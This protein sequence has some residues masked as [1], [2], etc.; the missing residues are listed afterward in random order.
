MYF[1]SNDVFSTITFMF[2][3]RM[4]L[5]LH[6]RTITQ[7]M[8]LFGRIATTGPCLWRWRRGWSRRCAQCQEQCSELRLLLIIIINPT[9]LRECPAELK[10]TI[11][12]LINILQVHPN[13]FVLQSQNLL[14]QQ[15]S[16]HLLEKK[17]VRPLYQNLLQKQN[18]RHLL[19]KK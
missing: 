3:F 4:L 7:P 16:R 2:Y 5:Y 11:E 13:L 15:N 17:V 9:N 8:C 19:E 12:E 10:K 1:L 18:S 14:Q 6:Y